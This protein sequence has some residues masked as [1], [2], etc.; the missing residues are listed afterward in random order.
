M[1]T[2]ISPLVL[3]CGSGQLAPLKLKQTSRVN[4]VGVTL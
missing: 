1:E 4:V 2:V 3:V